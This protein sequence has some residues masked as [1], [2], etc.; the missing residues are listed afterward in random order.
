MAAAGD[1]GGDGHAVVPSSFYGQIEEPPPGASSLPGQSDVREDEGEHDERRRGWTNQTPAPP[2][3]GQGLA[4]LSYDFNAEGQEMSSSS[5]ASGP[6]I[7][8]D[9]LYATVDESNVDDES[10]MDDELS[11]ESGLMFERGPP[12]TQALAGDEMYEDA[13]TVTDSGPDVHRK[14][15]VKFATGDDDDEPLPQP[16]KHT[17]AAT[18]SSASYPP[19]H[20]DAPSAE[21]DLPTDEDLDVSFEVC[22][23]LTSST[24]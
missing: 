2:G 7:Y 3:A 15:S 9:S 23:I 14:T 13:D 24:A 22:Y 18:E 5:S 6:K 8:L 11:F 19:G 20:P 17:T 10:N 16:P 4:A 21:V 1:H 12:N